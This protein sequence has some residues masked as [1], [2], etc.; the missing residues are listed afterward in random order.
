MSGQV[1]IPAN[2]QAFIAQ[3]RGFVEIAANVHLSK[4]ELAESS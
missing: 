2:V 3:K 1:E 4:P